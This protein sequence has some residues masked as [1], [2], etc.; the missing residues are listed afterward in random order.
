[1]VGLVLA[2]VPVALAIP[3]ESI[4]GRDPCCLLDSFLWI[5]IVQVGGKAS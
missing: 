5:V 4:Y 1:M 2:L 3:D